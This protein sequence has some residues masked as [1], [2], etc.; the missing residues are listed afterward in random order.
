MLCLF[1][2]S[3]F[4]GLI[5]ES[6]WSHY[7]RLFLGHAAYAQTLVLA[8][9][10]GGMA[11][12]A[13]L[14][15]R[16]S[17][18]WRDL[19]IAYALVEAAIGI[20]SLGFH[21]VFLDATA[22]VF[23]RLAPHFGSPAIVDLVKW[24]VGAALLLPQS[25]LLGATFPLLT[26]AVLRAQP[27]RAGYAI[28]MLYFTNSL[29]VA[30]GVLASGF[31]FIAAVGLPGTL[32]AAG[33]V[34]LAVAAAAMLLPR[35]GA[36]A[37][38]IAADPQR[39]LPGARLLLAVA[40]LTGLS[41]FLYEIGWIRMLA[42]VLGASTHAFELM[43]SAFIFGIAF[44]GL[45]VRR[46][47]D[48]AS[49][50]VRLLGFVQIAMGIAALATLPI[51]GSSFYVMR[52]ILEAVRPT[53]GGYDLF[54]VASHAI[55]LAVM[56]PAAFC[57]G[58]TLPLITASLLRLG[59]GEPAIGRVYAAN[60]AGAIAGVALAVHVG[61]PWLGVK[62][63]II[64]GAAIDLALGVALL[65]PR[66]ALT[67][68]AALAS[69]AALALATFGVRLE[70][71]D[72]ASGVYRD[73]V[74]FDPSRTTVLAH[75]DGKTS[76]VSVTR[77]N[78]Y[79]TLHSNG[80]PE[81]STREGAEPPSPDEITMALTGALPLLH[82]PQA[83]HA[84]VIGFGTGIS[85]H[86]LL[87]SPTL[88]S[89]DTIEIEPAVVRAAESFRPRNARAYEDP[90]SH[91]HFEDAKTYFSSRRQLYDLIVSEP[92]NPWVSGV[93]SLFSR[94]FYRDVRRR[95]APGG[96]L[97][98]WIQ[99]Y[100]MNPQVLA[101]VLEALGGEFPHYVLWTSNHV[102]LILVAARDDSVPEPSAQALQGALAAE[103]ARFSIRNLDD[104]RLHRL[105]GREAI[106]PYFAA[107]G[108][109]VNS[110]FQ[111]YVDLNAAKARFMRQAVSEL[112]ALRE[113]PLPLLDRF[114]NRQALR[115][116]PKRLTPGA[117]PWLRYA[118]ATERAAA[119]SAYL[120]SGD[121]AA[122]EVIGSPLADD[123]LTVR[124]A[125]VSCTVRAPLPLVRDALLRLAAAVNPYLAPALAGAVWAEL[126][127]SKCSKAPAL[128]AWLALHHAA[129]SGT[130][131][132]L[133]RSARSALAADDTLG[134]VER[135]YV[136]AALIGGQIL[137]GER[138]AAWRSFTEYRGRLGG[139]SGWQPVFRLLVAHT[140]AP[141][142]HSRSAESPQA[143]AR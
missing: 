136:V 127:A 16:W 115:P 93:A 116:D 60:T 9:F 131:A 114:E 121:G 29:G 137:A 13:W 74:L 11:L 49:D 3:G 30:V 130:P 132:E 56:F 69:M 135:P 62:G 139:G 123:A 86:T 1:T 43:L 92:S 32:I 84:A 126:R 37:T 55:A 44:G 27:E 76:T 85:T 31:Y 24:S 23:D 65:A 64:A 66:R 88:E 125:L 21:S 138:A 36:A 28:A 142:I 59:A 50:S 34:N 67:A 107:L 38:A 117:R 17:H 35:G 14:A 58:M 83:R 143:R 71:H 63:L 120:R 129:A 72:M 100:E 68:G 134:D 103:L 5:Y 102:D 45:W 33:I 106:G 18:G 39:T 53:E 54:N 112:D 70:P 124:A 95:L 12:G 8:M 7:L 119:V 78:T 140:D 52:W 105:A 111:P 19:L 6:I 51:Y 61:L 82:A 104:L 81:G 48:A 47:I 97:V 87:A 15:S 133:V 57:A 79:L 108:A 94:E 91:L 41:S 46:R 96:L 109:P 73:G 99:V 89:V 22:L 20:A 98:Q 26:G 10:M 122:L 113:S 75:L 101:S 110:D 4:A 128:Q 42:L 2:A 80:K 25:V 40:A 118:R 90:R 141:I 77:R